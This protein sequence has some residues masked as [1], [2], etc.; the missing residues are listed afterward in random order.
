VIVPF[1]IAIAAILI[2]VQ[3]K[4]RARLMSR[5]PVHRAD[6]YAAVPVCL[7]AIY[8]G[9]FGAGMGVMMLAVVGALLDDTLLRLNALKQTVTLTTNV[10]AALAFILMTDVDWLVT[11]V[12]AG[13]ALAGGLIGGV[14]AT[15]VPQAVLRWTIVVLGLAVAAV[16]FSR[17]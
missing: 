14:L 11:A 15:R 12:M 6:A 9:Y 16:Y 2:A 13:A 4:L 7:A 1:L 10:T 8:G 3:G 17:L 5:V